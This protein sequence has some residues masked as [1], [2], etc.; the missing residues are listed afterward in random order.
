LQKGMTR[1]AAPGLLLLALFG[2]ATRDCPERTMRAVMT[3]TR[4]ALRQVSTQRS[5]NALLLSGG[6][7]HG[8]WGAGVLS[9]WQNRPRFDVVTGV[10]TGALQCSHAFLGEFGTLSRI[11]TSVSDR[12][13][14]RE[15]W[16][17]AALFSNSL[18]TLEP[19]RALIAREL[20]DATIDRVAA[21][22]RGRGLFCATV[23]LDTGRLVI[24][25][26]CD[27]ARKKEYA[28]YRQVILASSSVPGLHPPVMIAGAMHA[29][30]GVRE[31]VFARKMMLDLCSVRRAQRGGADPGVTVY[32]VVNG[33]TSV[34]G[35]CTQ[36]GLL[37]IATRAVEI[38]ASANGGG[39]LLMTKAV[40]DSVRRL[41]AKRAAGPDK[42]SG[43]SG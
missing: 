23:N 37:D 43:V 5:V 35:A 4:S 1:Q 30:G 6:G 20:P 36:P 16:L 14:F 38:M 33:K 31:Q 9:G 39:N 8:A 21:E 27:L 7:S 42:L 10:S 18:T 29:D 22:S 40:A 41:I 13:I 17:I 24:W 19:L 25:D 2:C 26:L 3:D 34:P 32:V 11:Y 15:R 12:D 28:A